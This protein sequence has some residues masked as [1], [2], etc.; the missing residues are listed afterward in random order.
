M[1]STRYDTTHY[2]VNAHLLTAQEEADFEYLNVFELA[3]VLILNRGN[4]QIELN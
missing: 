4:R 2:S 1:G 3:D